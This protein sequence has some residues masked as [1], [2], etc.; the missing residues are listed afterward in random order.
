MGSAPIIL[1]LPDELLHRILSSACLQDP[2]PP[3]H[4][5][6]LWAYNPRNAVL[7]ISLTCS[8][9]WRIAHVF[10]FESVYIQEARIHSA[11]STRHQ[12]YHIDPPMIQSWLQIHNTTLKSIKIDELSSQRTKPAGYR[13]WFDAAK[14]PNLE[15]LHL[16]RW[17]WNSPLDLDDDLAAKERDALSILGAPRLRREE[18]W[19]RCLARAALDHRRQRGK[20]NLEEI[21][22]QFTPEEV[23]TGIGEEPEPEVEE[24]EE[25]YPWDRMDRVCEEIAQQSDG[26]LKLEY[27]PPAFSREKWKEDL[28]LK[29]EWRRILE[30]EGRPR[31]IPRRFLD[32]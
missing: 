6:R 22:I 31:R 26:L 28:E 9:F 16:S 8:H 30:T 5:A 15:N 23:G 19:L 21:W 20:C 14:F 17:L 25:V 7:N 2:P 27:N 12:K 24:K 11:Y 4:S 13:F 29:R 18:E 3:P 1:R 10:P 32:R